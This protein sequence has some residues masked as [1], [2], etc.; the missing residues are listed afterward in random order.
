MKKKKN[1]HRSAIARIF[2][3]VINADGVISEKELEFL[4]GVLKPK[5]QLS[6][7]DFDEA[8]GLSFVEAVQLIKREVGSYSGIS[9]KEL[10][11]DIDALA[12]ADGNVHTKEA[13]LCL[14]FRHAVDDG[15]NY[16]GVKL[17]SCNENHL[18]FS[19]KEI[20]YVESEVDALTNE[21]IDCNYELINYL[22]QSFGF[23]FVYIPKIK[24]RFLEYT[25]EYQKEILRYLYPYVD[26]NE[27]YKSFVGRLFQANTVDF[28]N[29]LLSDSVKDKVKP[30]LL[31]KIASTLDKSHDNM[32]DFILLDVTENG[33]LTTLQRFLSKYD[34]LSGQN[35]VQVLRGR[36]SNEFNGK[37]FHRTFVDY[38]NNMVSEVEIHLDH[39]H[40]PFVQLGSLGAFCPPPKSLALYITLLY[41]SHKGEPFTKE[42]AKANR[43]DEQ[44]KMF[45][46]VYQLITD[47]GVDSPTDD[48]YN[49][50]QVDYNKL[51]SCFGKLPNK[52]LHQFAPD[53]DKTTQT[54]GFGVLL[55]VRMVCYNRGK[56][57][58]KTI[59]PQDFIGFCEAL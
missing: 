13:L 23:Q 38:L 16:L 47:N 7:E 17:V 46:K 40:K 35:T 58:G 24:E 41:C 3:A 6:D 50:I 42:W 53:Y 37:S 27:M 55:P 32:T 19:K 4:E 25:D 18:K 20:I 31:I 15:A 2:T 21:V 52:Y 14:A 45:C 33:F 11:D 57:N 36:R 43:L 26:T 56:K 10:I 51:K 49:N 59:D 9:Y 8:G 12:W 29:M 28:T 48:F 30:S 1:S 5:Y 22:L 34:N 39:S 54:Y 44:Y